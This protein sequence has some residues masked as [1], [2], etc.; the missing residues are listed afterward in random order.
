MTEKKTSSKFDGRYIP[1]EELLDFIN[2]NA[3]KVSPFTLQLMCVF[4][5]AALEGGED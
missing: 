5:E 4:M 1:R 2:S 3:N